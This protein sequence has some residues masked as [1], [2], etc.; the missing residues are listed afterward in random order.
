MVPK[1]ALTTLQKNFPNKDIKGLTTDSAIL[2][3]DRIDSQLSWKR[4][5]RNLQSET[6]NDSLTH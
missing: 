1:V 3:I 6:M 5:D 4:C 2:M